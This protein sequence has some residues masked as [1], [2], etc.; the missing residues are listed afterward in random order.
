MYVVQQSLG[1]AVSIRGAAPRDPAPVPSRR[2][3]SCAGRNRQGWHLDNRIHA[4]LP[5]AGRARRGPVP[6]RAHPECATTCGSEPAGA[7]TLR[8]GRRDP[9]VRWQRPQGTSAAA[10]G[11]RR[12]TSVGHRTGKVSWAPPIAGGAGRRTRHQAHGTSRTTTSRAINQGRFAWTK[13]FRRS[14]I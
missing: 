3:R 2:G 10:D 4:N 13:M 14:K 8:G 1:G 9:F 12:R 7:M 5:S 6:W 11:P